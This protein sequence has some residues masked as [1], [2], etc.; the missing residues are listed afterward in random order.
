MPSKRRALTACVLDGRVYAIGG[1]DGSSWLNTAESFDPRTGVSMISSYICVCVCVYIYIYIRTHTCMHVS[2]CVYAIVGYDGSSW[3]N[4]AKSFD[5]RTGVSMNLY[6]HLCM[7]VCKFTM[8]KC[9]FYKY[10]CMYVFEHKH[11]YLC[12]FVCMS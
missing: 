1:Y 2:V 8:H 5:P 3:L 4:T 9:I 7:Y 11:M 10:A 12:I 6:T